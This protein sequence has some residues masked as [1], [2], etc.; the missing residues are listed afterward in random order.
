MIF[1]KASTLDAPDLVLLQT[2]LFDG[3]ASDADTFRFR[4]GATL[5]DLEYEYI[6]YTLANNRSASYA[7]VSKT[8]GISKKTLW[9]KRKRYNLDAELE[10]MTA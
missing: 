10:E 1:A 4:A 3:A 7:D 8:L 5:E 9:E 6:K 2:D